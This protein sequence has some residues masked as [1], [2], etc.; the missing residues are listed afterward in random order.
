[1]GGEVSCQELDLPRT[2]D[3]SR[4][5][6]ESAIHSEARSRRRKRVS[7]KTPDGHPSFQRRY[8]REANKQNKS[9]LFI[10]KTTK[11]TQQ[12][13][14]QRIHIS[15]YPEKY[16]GSNAPRQSCPFLIHSLTH[17]LT[18]L[19]SQGADISTNSSSTHQ[20]AYLR[21]ASPFTAIR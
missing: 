21:L 17:S 11:Q 1:M 4:I 12:T 8:K 2:S 18:Y 9:P 13:L 3:E 15:Q 14:S 6:E 7:R 16:P 10:L 5:T 20:N 19:P